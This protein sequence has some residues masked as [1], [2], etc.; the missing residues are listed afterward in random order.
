MKLNNII[1]L[2]R[3]HM[4]DFFSFAEFWAKKKEFLE[5]VSSGLF[6]RPKDKL[7]NKVQL[8]NQIFDWI[9]HKPLIHNMQLERGK[10]LLPCGSILRVHT[11]NCDAELEKM[12]Q[13]DAFGVV[14]LYEYLERNLRQ[15][16]FEVLSTLGYESLN[17]ESGVIIIN[18][19]GEKEL[20]PLSNPIE[21]NP[22]AILRNVA[23]INY[24]KDNVSI[25]CGNTSKALESGECLRALFWGEQCVKLLPSVQN[26]VRFKWLGESQQTGITVNDVVITGNILAFTTGK[27]GGYIYSID[28]KDK[29]LVSNHRNIADNYLFNPIEP[30]ERIVYMELNQN[31]TQCL[32][33]T[34]KMNLYLCSSNNDLEIK[35]S[36]S[37]VIMASFKNNQIKKI[38]TKN[39][40]K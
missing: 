4:R 19:S 28:S 38:K 40:Q 21:E 12:S 5:V 25:K 31:E 6:Y 15:D 32:L 9:N 24:C 18:S 16:I 33:L 39:I 7:N 34:D 20:K 10:I 2:N 29:K 37:G 35:R 8:N 13:E 17:I 22:T 27:S 14:C 1:I 11:M 3:Q 23:I 30:D 36:D 26:N